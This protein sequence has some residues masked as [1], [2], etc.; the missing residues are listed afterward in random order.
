M[1]SLDDKRIKQFN[2]IDIYSD[3]TLGENESLTI[4]FVLQDDD[5]TLEDEDIT[6]TMDDI[7]KVLDTKLDIK[8]R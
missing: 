8:L 3:E 1:N 7:L 2:L 6:K 4:R 5:K